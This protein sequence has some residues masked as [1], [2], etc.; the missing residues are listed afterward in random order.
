MPFGGAFVCGVYDIP[1]RIRACPFNLTFWGGKLRAYYSRNW[2]ASS[3]AGTVNLTVWRFLINGDLKPTSSLPMNQN[4]RPACNAAFGVTYFTGY[5]DY[6]YDCSTNQWQIAWNLN[7]ECDGVHHSPASARPA[8]SSG[9]HPTRSYSFVGPGNTFSIQPINLQVSNGQII[10][11]AMRKNDWINSPAIC[12]FEEPAT[13]AFTATSDFC[14][15]SG[16]GP[17]QYNMAFVQATGA[18]GSSVQPSPLTMLMQKRLGMWTNP[19]VYPGIEMLL[20]DFGYLDHKDGCTGAGAPEWFE[21]CET[22]R[23]YPAVDFTGVNLGTQFED[24]G[25]CNQSPTAPAIF[26]GAPHVVNYVL[27]FNLP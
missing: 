21:G 18:C 1:V 13:G 10:Q 26:I 9:F 11:Q 17:K 12:T 6:V 15:C 27:N 20:F 24:L 2:Q 19:N 5:I 8:P 7:H 25:S 4:V 22:I 23:G 3:V 16:N 14:Q